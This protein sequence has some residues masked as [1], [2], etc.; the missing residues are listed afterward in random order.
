MPGARES[1][2][3]RGKAAKKKWR[4]S[5]A[6]LGN[7]SY[8]A[9][10][11]SSVDAGFSKKNPLYLIKPNWR[12]AGS[13]YDLCVLIQTPHKSLSIYH[14]CLVCFLVYSLHAETERLTIK[15]TKIKDGKNKNKPVGLS[16]PRLVQT[17]FLGKQAQI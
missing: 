7:E 8:H 2:S 4:E 5:E 17:A 6:P 10:S 12:A 11:N 14:I 9:S 3:G 1:Q 16:M 13:Q 15:S